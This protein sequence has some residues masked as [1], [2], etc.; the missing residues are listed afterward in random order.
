MKRGQVNKQ[1]PSFL[2]QRVYVSAETIEILYPGLPVDDLPTQDTLFDAVAAHDLAEALGLR[3][4]DEVN[5]L[6]ELFEDL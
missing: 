2:R 5:E 1:E 4:H 3:K 6:E